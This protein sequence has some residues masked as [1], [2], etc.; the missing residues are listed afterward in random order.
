MTETRRA[1]H[2]ELAEVSTDVIRLGAMVLEAIQASTAALLNTDLEAVEAVIESGVHPDLLNKA[3]E[4]RCYQL[5]ARQQPM[6]IDL[7]TIVA[8]L[9]V[10]HELELT[11]HLMISIAKAARRLYPNQL[12]P[13]LRGIID[14]MREQASE[15]LRLAM[16]A[17][18]DQDQ[19]KA[20]ALVDM[21]DAMGELQQVLF[22]AIFAVSSFDDSGIQRAVQIALVARYFERAADHAVNIGERVFYML[23]GTL[24]SSTG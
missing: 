9:R 21:D 19:A 8:V 18:A 15:E 24:P 2:E 6:A 5:L 10:N 20:S 13:R 7:R 3:I 22:R 23:T 17:F 12:E 11:A 16:D 1:F 14:R 4:D